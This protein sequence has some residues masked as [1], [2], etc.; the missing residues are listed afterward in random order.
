[1]RG[2]P[3]KI[4]CRGGDDDHRCF[5]SELDVIESVTGT[6]DLGVNLAAGNRFECDGTD[7]LACTASHHNV[8]F[9]ARLCKQTRQPH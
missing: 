1:M 7:E 8:D 6:E 2:A 3:D 9:G 4:R 5:S